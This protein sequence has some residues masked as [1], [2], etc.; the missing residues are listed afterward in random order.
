[1]RAAGA[2]PAQP[3]GIEVDMSGRVDASGGLHP[4]GTVTLDRVFLERLI[5][6][7]TRKKK[8]FGDRHVVYD[9]ASHTYAGDVQVKV[10]GHTLNLVGKVVPVVDQNQPGFKFESLGLKLG[11]FTLRGGLLTK[12]ATKLIAQAITDDGIGAT[13][14][15]NG[16]I[17]LNTTDLLHDIEVLPSSM[18]VD[19]NTRFSAKMD[20]K[21][22]VEVKL[23]S[24]TPAATG[25]RTPLSDLSVAI[26]ADA[27]RHMLTPV[28]APDYQLSTVS[29]GPGSISLDGQVE[30]KPISDVINVAKGLL[31]AIIGAN[32]GHVGDVRTEKAMIGLKLDAKLQGTQVVLTPSLS[33]ALGDLESTLKKA[34]LNPVR[35][36]RSLRFDLKPLVAE[37]GVEGIEAVNGQLKGR[38]KLDINSLLKAPILRG[39]A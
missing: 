23:E 11:P 8:T 3:A 24:D 31:A 27:L 13:P 5:R 29:V 35:E 17:R 25:P 6:Q 10:K 18:H 1:V 20:A 28:L 4:T 9:A 33:A 14:G 26:D 19:A 16:V 2:P 39:E 30:A 38:A 7:V 36:G 32:G 34:G 21:G 15:P 22:G 12:L 37:Y